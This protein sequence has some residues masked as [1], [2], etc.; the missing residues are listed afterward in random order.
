MPKFSQ[1]YKQYTLTTLAV[2]LMAMFCA[3]QQQPT[4]KAQPRPTPP[5]AAGKVTRATLGAVVPAG[6]C[7]V[8]VQLNG[9][10]TT[11]GPTEVK[12]TW[13]SSDNSTWPQATL[14]FTQAGTQKAATT[15]QLGAAYTGWVQLKVLSP[16]AILSPRANFKVTCGGA[17]T[18]GA[19]KVTRATLVATYPRGAA[20]PV[21]VTFHGTIATNGAATVKYTWVSMDG[22]TWPEGT[23]TFARAGTNS[24][25]ESR[26]VFKTETGW[27]QLKV[28]SPNAVLS[29]RASYVITCPAKK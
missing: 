9:T 7:P 21:T 24:V 11:N 14:N 2:F 25:T 12:Y 27:M 1:S 22:G 19:G 15:W 16:N 6:K 10:I 3:A 5:K 23:T 8:T 17:T 26:Q 20:C 29:P 18:G 13:L 4:S 28:L